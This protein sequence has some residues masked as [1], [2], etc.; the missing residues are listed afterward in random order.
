M[1][2]S[3]KWLFS[4]VISCVLGSLG[5][6][7]VTTTIENNLNVDIG[8]G[9]T[10]PEHRMGWAGPEAVEQAKP[11]VE[12]M[13]EFRIVGE[14]GDNDD[15]NVRLWKAAIAVTGS[16]LPNYPQQVGDCVAFGAK[17]AVEYLQC[18]QMTRGPPASFRPIF[19][20]YIYGTSRVQIGEG[21]LRGDG[22][23]GAWA[24]KA[25]QQYGVLAADHDRCPEY[26]GSISR[27]WGR[28]GPPEWALDE[29][30]KWPVKTVAQ[31][32]TAEE[33]REALCH[34]YPL[35]VASSFGS[36]DFRERD[37]R[38]VARGNGS[39]S[40]QMCLIAYDGSAP[41]GERYFYCLNSWGAKAHPAPLGDEPPGGFW[42]T[43]DQCD[44]IVGQGDSFA[45][46]AFEGFPAQELDFSI[47]RTTRTEA[48]SWPVSS[49]PACSPSPFALA[50]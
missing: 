8:D 23:V 40:H 24:A 37:G 44:R 17:N 20:S 25:V 28:N 48:P 18:V 6:L 3:W 43:W 41:S 30:R 15:K 9:V 26:S 1:T 2:F 5:T 50:L 38:L 33:A 31:V 49:R 13:P 42:I 46:S 11:I 35:T 16:H 27:E 29:G 7:T 36:R 45:F 21:R 12:A 47:F 14:V 34:G 4:C 22:S 19:P 39:W 32:S 10:P